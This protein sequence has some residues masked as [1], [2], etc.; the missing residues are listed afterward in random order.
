M[1]VHSLM[2]GVAV[3]VLIP[4]DAYWM[5]ILL[6]ILSGALIF[7]LLTMVTELTIT[8]PTKAAKT[9]VTMITK[10]Q[11]KKLFWIGV[12]L[13]G[14]VLP[15]IVINIVPSIMTLSIGA[16]L[17]LA[18]IYVTEKIWIEAPQRVPLA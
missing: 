13:V 11:Y 3:F 9:V 12:V 15:L 8:H 1:L 6:P 10:G 5:R 7:N 18:G 2:A 14:N 16:I 17:V 4:H